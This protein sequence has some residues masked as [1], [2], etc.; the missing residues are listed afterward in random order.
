MIKAYEALERFDDAPDTNDDLVKILL[1][2]DNAK[3]N[4]IVDSTI[5]AID[6]KDII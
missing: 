1:A 4:A 5:P 2:T 6:S 3:K